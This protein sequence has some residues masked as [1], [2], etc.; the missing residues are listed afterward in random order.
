MAIRS[1]FRLTWT[2]GYAAAKASSSRPN[3]YMK[4]VESIQVLCLDTLEMEL[5]DHTQLQ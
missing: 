2:A 4:I 3:L 5:T 1:C